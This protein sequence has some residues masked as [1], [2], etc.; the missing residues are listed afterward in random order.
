M[1]TTV[2]Q[3]RSIIRERIRSKLSKFSWNEFVAAQEGLKIQGAAIAANNYA[4]RALQLLGKGSSRN[5]YVLTSKTVLKIAKFE[6]T[7]SGADGV[8]QNKNEREVYEAHKDLPLTRVLKADDNDVW[9]VSELVNPI[10][11][12]EEFKKLTGFSELELDDM[13]EYDFGKRTVFKPKKKQLAK[14]PFLQLLKRIDASGIDVGDLISHEQWGKNADGEM[15][16]LDS[17]L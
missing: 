7:V 14:S 1:Q 3:L 16:L 15:K 8:S 10:N 11:N 2:G 5:T 9:L 13:C 4:S 6:G 12:D 17:G